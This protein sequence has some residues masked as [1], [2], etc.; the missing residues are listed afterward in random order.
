MSA[1]PVSWHD[2]VHKC[3][4]VGGEIASEC[5]F[6][7]VCFHVTGA[8]NDNLLRVFGWK[9][10]LRALCVCV[11]ASTCGK[12]KELA[13]AAADLKNHLSKQSASTAGEREKKTQPF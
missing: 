1:K 13:G 8:K 2:C 3:V 9:P 7:K 4:E 10:L 12:G 11:C 6:L 5:W